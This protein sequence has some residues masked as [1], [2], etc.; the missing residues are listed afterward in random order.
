MEAD[1]AAAKITRN[2]D[3]SAWE[4]RGSSLFPR[5]FVSSDHAGAPQPADMVVGDMWIRHP[6]DFEA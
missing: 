1:I 2:Y 5:I 4:A 3:G 6:D